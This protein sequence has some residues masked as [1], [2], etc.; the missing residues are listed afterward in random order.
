MPE[1]GASECLKMTNFSFWCCK[2]LPPNVEMS[3]TQD[4]GGSAGGAM[5]GE[6][7]SRDESN[8]QSKPEQPVKHLES[9]EHRKS[10]GSAT[11]MTGL[12]KRA[13]VRLICF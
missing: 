13:L 1:A 10:R 2:L 12:I 8:S 7:E 6:T 4:A 11:D 5:E 3:V 9:T